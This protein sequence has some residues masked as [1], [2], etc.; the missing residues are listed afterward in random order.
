L[1]VRFQEDIHLKQIICCCSEFFNRK[2]FSTIRLRAVILAEVSN[3]I[4][5]SQAWPVQDQTI[6]KHKNFGN[7]FIQGIA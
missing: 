7:I 4:I 2:H 6:S 5:I 3:L 1:K